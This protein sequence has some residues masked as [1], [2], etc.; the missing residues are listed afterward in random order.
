MDVHIFEIETQP[1]QHSY[2]VSPVSPDEA[3]QNGLPAI[4]I[5]GVLKDGEGDLTPENF[6][7]NRT[8]LD[9][10]HHFIAEQ[11]AT[12]P[13]LAE[14]ASKIEGDGMVFVVDQRADPEEEIAPED[15]LGAFRT[16]NG[17]IVAGSFQASPNHKLLT[18]NGLFRLTATLE[19]ELLKQMKVKVEE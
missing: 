5:I 14:E 10:F 16:Q 2:Y 3:M 13:A 4:A 17:A 19:E 11:M 18:E 1:D 6:L 12:D 7:P 15:I 9:F 8:F